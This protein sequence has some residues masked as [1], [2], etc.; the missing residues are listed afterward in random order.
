VPSLRPF[1]KLL[2][3]RSDRGAAQLPRP[4]DA[5]PGPPVFIVV[6]NNTN[7]SKLVFDYVAGWENT[8]PQEKVVVPGKLGL[9]SNVADG[10]WISRPNTILVDSAQLE[11]GE[12]ES[13]DSAKSPLERSKS[14]RLNIAPLPGKDAMSL[15]K[16]FLAITVAAQWNRPIH[17]VWRLRRRTLGRAGS[18]KLIQH[19]NHGRIQLPHRWFSRGNDV[20]SENNSHLLGREF[21]GVLSDPDSFAIESQH[22]LSVAVQLREFSVFP[23]RLRFRRNPIQSSLPLKAFRSWFPVPRGEFRLECRWRLAIGTHRAASRSREIF[24]S[25]V[26]LLRFLSKRWLAPRRTRP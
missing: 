26:R 3:I 12:A 6:C 8:L 24:P 15:T 2:P 1:E 9:F 23:T 17:A 4:V 13:E 18:C 10:V 19:T 20:A 25:D 5:H 11:S 16:I 22:Q 21:D 14:S 7:V